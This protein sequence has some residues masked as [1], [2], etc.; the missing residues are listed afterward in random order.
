MN[1]LIVVPRII[2][3]TGD[4][5]MFPQGLAYISAALGKAGFNLF[6]LN[7]NHIETT[8]EEALRATIIDNDIDVIMTGGLTG[9]YG[10]IQTIIS[11]ANRIKDDIINI[12]GGGIITS[13]PE[14][15]MEAICNSQI[16]VI[17]EGE[18]IIE[19]ICTTLEEGGDISNVPGVI[20]YRDG[21]LIRSQGKPTP[22]N[23]NSVPIPDYDGL[24][25]D[26]LLESTPNIIGMSD[27]NTFPIITSRG[28]PFSCTFCFHP[29]GMKYRQ[30]DLDNVFEEIDLLREKYN[31]EY[32][33]VQ[34]ELFGFN[35]DRVR[36]FCE[37]IKPY[38]MKWW[39]QFRVT[40][41]T[42]ELV[43][44]LKGSN[45][46]A[47]GLGIESADDRILESMNKKIKLENIENALD[48]V[49]N[50]GLGI[51]GNLIFG[52]PEE[53]IESV[54]NSLDWWKR[55]SKY[56]LQLSLIVTYPGTGIFKYAVDKGLITDPVQHI[57]DSCP[58]IK[59]S[60]MSDKEYTWMVE[61]ILSLQ[62]A[63][64]TTPQKIESYQIDYNHANMDLDGYCNSCEEK[65]SWKEI[66]FFIS[67]SISCKR[68]GRRHYAPIPQE[69]ADG[70]KAT[71]LKLIEKYGKIAFWGIN[72][73]FYNLSEKM[74]LK[75]CESILYVDQSEIRA[76]VSIGNCK[77]R[78]TDTINSENVRCVIVTVP[79]YFSNLKPMIETSF[80]G[81]ETVL[82]I[83]DLLSD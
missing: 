51:Q 80:N 40:Q 32:L 67:E 42:E 20:Y 21:E 38:N 83:S 16:G 66:R 10:A 55:N 68:C 45:C 58:T 50:A 1:Y 34:D 72:S 48:L 43:E 39:A 25:L 24:G 33:S 28:C 69:V 65:N 49:Y 61:E 30:R 27:E 6:K 12:I 52:D 71:V 8:V 14:Y 19:E 59:L 13:S 31:I 76:G 4:F 44:L 46:A 29:S 62:R 2:N 47:I 70:V 81:V 79:Q 63:S 9:Q 5:Y 64:L 73:Y 78:L 35:M 56:G 74:N 41:I 53:T 26:K 60:K 17:G 57:K 23:V 54:R 36:E 77:I 22:V 82:N 15:A 3:K 37:R 18:L 7:L 11:E 75:D